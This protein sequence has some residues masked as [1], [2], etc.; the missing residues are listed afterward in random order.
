M[1][2]LGRV[3]VKKNMHNVILVGE[4]GVGKTC[5]VEGFAQR[6][7]HGRV[8]E[9][10]PQ[11]RIIEISAGA[12]VAGTRYRGEFEE[13]IQRVLVEAS[14]NRDIILFIDEIHLLIGAG[15]S[16]GSSIDAA[17]LLKPA[18]ARG[19]I[20]CIGATTLREYTRYIEPDA[21]LS[22]RFQVIPVHEPTRTE[23]LEIL[24]GV[25]PS[26]EAHHHLRIS[27]DA[28]AASVEFS[29]RYM[30]DMRF[31]RKALDLLDEACAHV[32]LQQTLMAGGAPASVNREHV[33]EVVAAQIGMP[34]SLLNGDEAGHLLELEEALRRRVKGQDEALTALSDAVRAAHAGLLPANRPKGVFL[35]LGATGTGKTELAKALA[36]CLFGTEQA[37]VRLDMSEYAEGHSISRLIGSPPGYVGHEQE[38]Q[39]TSALRAQPYCVLLLDEIEKAHPDVLKLFL[40]VF[41]EGRLTTAHGHLVSFTEAIIIMTSNLGSA[42]MPAKPVGFS[43]DMTD[44]DADRKRL[45]EDAVM[46]AIHQVMPAELFNRI[47]RCIIFNPLTRATVHDIID[48]LLIQLNQQLQTHGITLTLADPVY[49]LLMAKGY[50]EAYGVRALERALRSLITEPLGREIIAGTMRKNTCIVAHAA[51]EIVSFSETKKASD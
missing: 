46:H 33:C 8:A 39:L 41:D 11:Q 18:L 44:D 30:P 9:G 29:L 3:L 24:H 6:M 32:R 50:S 51:G 47:D 23:T 5:V 49:D 28:L 27:D 17:N 16:E 31:P 26:Y 19:E 22:S 15:S 20:R 14:D 12:L 1:L 42:I 37:L 43:S 35:F 36:A 25:R 7:A 10:F 34:P 40:Q 48:K 13:R 38:G 45:R 2:R 4:A 21:A